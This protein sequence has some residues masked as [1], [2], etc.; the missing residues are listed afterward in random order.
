MF[1]EIDLESKDPLYA[2]LKNQIVAG[3]A[4]GDLTP[5]ESLPSV[6]ALGADLG[7]NLHTVNKA[8][9]QLEQEGFILIQRQKG[10]FIHPEGVA[11]ADE[12]YK[13]HLKKQLR[14]L[15]ADSVCRSM[16]EEEFV[17]LSRELFREFAN[18]EGGE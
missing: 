14:P 6:R 9:R 10:V 15:I 7:I 8:Y 17:N 2:Q 13:N 1:I 3:I 4:R 11:P 12:E 5:G 18:G 16:S